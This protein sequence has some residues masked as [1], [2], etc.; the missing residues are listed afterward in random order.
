MSVFGAGECA[1]I[2]AT[3]C[4]RDSEEVL[5]IF[6]HYK[7]SRVET[8]TENG[9]TKVTALVFRFGTADERFGVFLGKGTFGSVWTK[10]SNFPL[11]AK[12][13]QG[14]KEDVQKEVDGLKLATQCAEII[15]AR[16]LHESEKYIVVGMPKFDGTLFK[17]YTECNGNNF[18]IITRLVASAS[19]ALLEKGVFPG[20]V[21]SE[22]ILS[23]V[24]KGAV[25]CIQFADF[26]SFVTFDGTV[27]AKKEDGMT[28]EAPRNLALFDDGKDCD[29]L[30]CPD[31]VWSIAAA[32]VYMSCQKRKI[33][34]RS[35]K[36][37]ATS[38]TTYRMGGGV[39]QLKPILQKGDDYTA[40][41]VASLERNGVFRDAEYG[42]VAEYA[43][44]KY[45]RVTLDGLIQSAAVDY[46]AA[47]VDAKIGLID[48]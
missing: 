33:F 5:A 36:M 7:F 24:E 22:N 47:A 48:I 20:D 3:S 31:L 16:I 8:A 6:D 29:T 44:K 25:T 42:S 38:L 2:S 18:S 4:H 12:I 13:V 39:H 23:R 11:C 43:F 14:G 35:V 46:A 41:I 19:K 21:K 10:H 1:S 34:P 45:P 9:K 30:T 40:K 32:L 28:F 15:P 26:G 27:A 37:L 17:A